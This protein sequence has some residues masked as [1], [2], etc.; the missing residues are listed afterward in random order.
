MKFSKYLPIFAL[1][2]AVAVSLCAVAVLGEPESDVSS[3][4]S[5]SPDV[6][7]QQNTDVQIVT[8]N[9]AEPQQTAAP[10]NETKVVGVT[11]SPRQ[12]DELDMDKIETVITSNRVFDRFVYNDAALIEEAQITLL[13]KTEQ[14][15]GQTVIRRDTVDSF[16]AALYGREIKH[17]DDE[18]YY[19]VAPRG[20]DTL[21]HRILSVEQSND[22]TVTVVTAMTASSTIGECTVTTV[23]SPADTEF[24]YIICS[25]EITE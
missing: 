8:A 15:D 13:D 3:V 12:A 11:D 23:L 9:T 7:A 17:D 4:V 1:I 14:L 22:G 20:F 18:E 25:A 6:N 24:G 2:F 5:L 21:V 16:I 10:D 19:T